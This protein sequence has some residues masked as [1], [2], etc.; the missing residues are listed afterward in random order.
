MAS[1]PDDE[2]IE[3]PAPIPPPAELPVFPTPTAFSQGKA[4]MGDLTKMGF[5]LMS[6]ALSHQADP[7]LSA[8]DNA[9]RLA[10]N[11][12]S[13][14]GRT[15]TE[16]QLTDALK[17]LETEHLPEGIAGF[18]I[19]Q[20]PNPGTLGHEFKLRPYDLIYQ[21]EQVLVSE[22]TLQRHFSS[23]IQAAFLRSGFAVL[24]VYNFQSRQY[25]RVTI[26]MPPGKPNAILGIV[27]SK[28]PMSNAIPGVISEAS[29]DICAKGW[30]KQ[31]AMYISAG[32][33][34]YPIYAPL[35]SENQDVYCKIFRHRQGMWVSTNE[36]HPLY[37]YSNLEEPLYV[38]AWRHQ[39][40]MLIRNG[41]YAQLPST[42]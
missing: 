7:H 33:N 13:I 25:R 9:M 14:T 27:C 34:A 3:G 12:S 17:K 10:N 23:E 6:A 15:Q 39:N 19:T 11:V 37:N 30:K 31:G 4:S 24:G 36:Y 42:R 32:N 2:I 20:P 28:L 35:T 26:T 22:D 29:M 40:G 5:G 18:V 8:E 21:Y 16:T 38:E 41:E 1:C